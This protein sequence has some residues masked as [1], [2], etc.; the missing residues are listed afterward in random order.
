MPVVD[1]SAD[2]RL[3]DLPTYERTYG[4]HGAPQLSARGRLRPHGASPRA[5]PRGEA[6]RQPGLLP[7]SGPAGARAARRGRAGGRRRDQRRVGGLGGR[8]GRGERLAFVNVD[9]NFSPYGVDGHRHAPEIVQELRGLGSSAPVSFVPHLLPLDQGLLASCYVRLARGVGEEELRSLYEERYADEPFV[10]LVDEPPGVRDVRDT[11]LCRVHVSLDGAGR[12]LAFAAIDNL[13]KGAAGQAIQNLNLMLG[14]PRDGGPGMTF[15]RSRWVD[16]PAGV[17]ELDPAELAP[18]FTAAGVACGLKDGG[19]TDLGLLACDAETVS[20]ALLLTRNAAAAAPVRVCREQC[21]RAGIR[22][23][24]V[25][26]GNANAAVG[27]RGYRDALADARCRGASAST[28]SP[29]GGD[30]RDRPDRRS[31]GDRR[32]QGR[33]GRGGQRPVCARRRRLRAGDHDHRSRPEAL[34][35]ARRRCHHL[36]PGQGRRDDRAAL[37]DHAVLPPDRRPGARARGGTARRRSP[38]RSSGSPSTAR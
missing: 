11:N 35:R 12:A 32:G 7:D 6:G 31:A 5:D 24:V 14:L 16:A 3:H 27:E 25:N 13:W 21:D 20:S 26:S 10:E 19:S 17:E 23:A 2:F 34:H 9:E 37:R 28:R 1:I 30:R 15:F 38:T 4:D 22:A 18:G 33:R 36:R 8:T 29:P